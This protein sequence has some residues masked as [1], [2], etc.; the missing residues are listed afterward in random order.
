M[1]SGLRSI[2]SL[3]QHLVLLLQ[4]NNRLH[5]EVIEIIARRPS[6][7]PDTQIYGFPGAHP[8][9]RLPLPRPSRSPDTRVR[10]AADVTQVT[11]ADHAAR[12]SAEQRLRETVK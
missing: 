11:R 9:S 1:F 5:R 3:L 6:T 8:D 2:V 12:I 7:V 10:T 4:E